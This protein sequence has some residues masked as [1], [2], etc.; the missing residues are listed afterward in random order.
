MCLNGHYF[1]RCTET[2]MANTCQVKANG[3]LVFTREDESDTVKHMDVAQVSLL[4]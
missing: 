4:V 2:V 1:Y 3:Q